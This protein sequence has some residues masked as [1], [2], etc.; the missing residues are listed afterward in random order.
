MA[1]QDLNLVPS[2]FRAQA[3]DHSPELH[4]QPRAPSLPSPYHRLLVG[5]VRMK[6]P[7]V[8]KHEALDCSVIAGSSLAQDH[9]Y[10]RLGMYSCP[11][12]G[13]S[14]SFVSAAPREDDSCYSRSSDC[15]IPDQRGAGLRKKA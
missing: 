15:S 4:V 13:T 6:L 2:H 3:P 12:M 9:G 11:G 7:K 1:E 14:T 5:D 10:Q 8:P